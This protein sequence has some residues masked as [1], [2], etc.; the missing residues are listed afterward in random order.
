MPWMESLLVQ[1]TR[2][3]GSRELWALRCQCSF[4]RLGGC[5]SRWSLSQV[6]FIY[7]RHLHGTLTAIIY[8]RLRH[9]VLAY[10]ATSATDSAIAPTPSHKALTPRI[11]PHTFLLAPPALRSAYSALLIR[12]VTL[13]QV[14]PLPHVHLIPA[15]YSQHEQRYST[16]SKSSGVIFRPCTRTG[17]HGMGSGG[18]DCYR[19]R[20]DDLKRRWVLVEC[21]SI[22][23]FFVYLFLRRLCHYTPTRPTLHTRTHR[24]RHPR[25]RRH[26]TFTNTEIQTEASQ[27]QASLFVKYRRAWRIECS[28]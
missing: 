20:D 10:L 21:T 15:A 13:S 23:N 5:R 9:S 28:S 18:S 17:R 14:L 19:H 8:H 2:V 7:N 3:K 22:I 24:T 11:L 1:R 6:S 26:Q 12:L 25:N 16:S 4:C 27:T